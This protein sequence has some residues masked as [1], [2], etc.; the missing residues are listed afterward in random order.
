M[1]YSSDVAHQLVLRN[2]VKEL[3]QVYVNYPLVAL[4]EV[5]QQLQYGLLAAPAGAEAVAALLELLLEDGTQHLHYRL[6]KRTVND[7]RDAQPANATVRLRD[8]HTTDGGGLVAP[9]KD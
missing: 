3:L 2:V 8:F 7:R 6:L 9:L 1:D 5:F 4:V